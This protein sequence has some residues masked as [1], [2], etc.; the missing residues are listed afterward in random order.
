ME[1]ICQ[2][3]PFFCDKPGGG[4]ACQRVDGIPGSFTMKEQLPNL[5]RHWICKNMLAYQRFAQGDWSR[6]NFLEIMNR[7]NRYISRDALTEN[8]ISFDRLREFYRDK[9]WMCDRLTTMETH[10][11]I[12]KN[13]PPYAGMNFIRQGMDTRST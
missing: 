5:F 12:L 10:V 8:R 13:L 3:Q 1:K 9:D 4:R 6:K 7:P 11:K 2:T